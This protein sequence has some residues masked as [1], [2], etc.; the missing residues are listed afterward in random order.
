M[1]WG[2]WTRALAMSRTKCNPGQCPTPSRVLQQ[3]Y[4]PQDTFFYVIPLTPG[5]LWC[6]FI[7]T[8]VLPLELSSALFQVFVSPSLLFLD[9]RSS[10]SF[11]FVVHLSLCCWAKV[12]V[13]PKDETHYASVSWY[14]S[15]PWPMCS[16]NWL[17]KERPESEIKEFKLNDLF[18]LR[19]PFAVPN[20]CVTGVFMLCHNN[21]GP[22]VHYPLSIVLC[23]F[24]PLSVC[25]PVGQIWAVSTNKQQLCLRLAWIEK[26]AIGSQTPFH[27]AASLIFL[28]L[29]IQCPVSRVL[30]LCLA[31][32][33]YISRSFTSSKD[34]QTPNE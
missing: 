31:P 6:V 32:S 13:G 15:L 29:D 25:L 4:S 20:P 27:A 28:W 3:A 14:L 10:L 9:C 34:Q 22:F 18:F 11:C 17:L 1:A 5:P 30:R 21:V 16:S 12:L 8:L 7:G 19:K 24:P 26:I 33:A 23:P 2:F